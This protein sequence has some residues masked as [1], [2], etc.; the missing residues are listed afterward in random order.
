M[1]GANTCHQGFYDPV[2]ERL[3]EPKH[4]GI[5]YSFTSD[6]FY[7]AAYYRAIANRTSRAPEHLSTCS[8]D[9]VSYRANMYCSFNA[10]MPQ[11]NNAM[12]TRQFRETRQRQPAPP[13]YQGRR[14]TTVQR[15]M[16]VQKLGVH[17]L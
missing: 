17:A 14:P 12:A 7:E 3:I 13:A 6:G 1:T 10:P 15:P 2:G 8:H 11:G 4:T 5:S 16:P 9:S